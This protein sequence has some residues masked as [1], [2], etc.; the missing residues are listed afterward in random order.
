MINSLNKK[1]LLSIVLLFLISISANSQVI[2]KN[3]KNHP[4]K[5]IVLYAIIFLSPIGLALIDHKFNK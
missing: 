2:I 5:H 1:K 4:K 3:N